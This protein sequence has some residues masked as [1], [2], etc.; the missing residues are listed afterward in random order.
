MRADGELSKEEFIS[1]KEILL[2]EQAH[3]ES[4]ITDTKS[5][6]HN[7]LEL[8][9][10]FLNTVFHAREIMENGE[11]E[12]KRN[13]IMTLGENLKLRD[14]KLKFSFRQPYDV[15]LLPEYRTNV[16]RG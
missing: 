4:L 8:T 9:E 5:T 14:E 16:L 2:K 7:W 1:Q 6:E 15:L 12:E 13:L 3:V 10:N 11:P